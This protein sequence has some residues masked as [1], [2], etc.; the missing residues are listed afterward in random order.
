MYCRRLYDDGGFDYDA[1]FVVAN[2]L[3]VSDK[4]IV[5]INMIIVIT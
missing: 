3:A 1:A 4:Q 2:L 5:N